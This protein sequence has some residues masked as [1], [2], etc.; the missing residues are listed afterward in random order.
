MVAVHVPM[1]KR[2]ATNLISNYVLTLVSMVL[3]F[4]LVPFLI[5]KLGK[6][7]YGLIVLAES[8]VLVFE[9]ITTSSRIA[10]SR[11]AAFCFAE[12]K[13]EEFVDYLSTGR[14]I[15]YVSASLVLVIAL[16]LSGF[17]SVIFRVPPQYADSA[18]QLFLAISGAF[19]ITIA[20]SVYWSVLYAHH[21]FDLLN[22]ATSGG[23]IVR[24]ACL[25]ILFSTLPAQHVNLTLYGFVYLAMVFVENSLVYFWSRRIMPDLRLSLKRFRRDKLREILSFTTYSSLSRMNAV[26]YDSIGG[27]LINRLWGPA[28]NAVFAV[29]TKFPS[30]MERLFVNAAWSMTPVL[31][32][33]VARNDREQFTRLYATYTKLITTITAPL[34]FVLA[35]LAGPLLRFWVGPDFET[36][37]RMMPILMAPLFIII[38]FSISGCITNSYAKVKFPSQMGFVSSLTFLALSV[39]FGKVLSLELIGVAMAGA[40]ASVG[41]ATF[42]AVY[43]CRIASLSFAHYF[44]TAYL[45]PMLWSALVIGG[46]FGAAR[47]LGVD[48]SIRL[49]VITMAVLLVLADYTGAYFVVLGSAERKQIRDL[50][51]LALSRMT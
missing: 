24:A 22:V 47:L 38:P 40:I 1:L 5:G 4:I 44:R 33:F 39:F 42:I 46:A 17:F 27:I 28:A 23:L 49:S 29:A 7:A 45:R 10:L 26:L 9:V 3:G 43:A 8:T 14:G 11:H 16:V 35:L 50:V 20:N 12:G 18:R 37:G 30:L 36:A 25:L 2:V 19:L 51:Q 21:R 41:Y 13:K 48:L 15:T 32:G 6:E 34:C 31:T